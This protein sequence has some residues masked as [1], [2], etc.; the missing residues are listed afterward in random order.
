[1]VYVVLGTE[2]RASSTLGKHPAHLGTSPALSLIFTSPID[3]DLMTILGQQR[4][5]PQ[6]LWLP[7]QPLD[8]VLNHDCLLQLV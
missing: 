2:P 3:A 7:V 6:V 8:S 4:Q 5:T 1:M